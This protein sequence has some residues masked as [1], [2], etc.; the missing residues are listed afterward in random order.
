AVTSLDL[1]GAQLTVANGGI[2]VGS[3]HA[4]PLAISNGTMTTGGANDLIIHN[5]GTGG[6]TISVDIVGATQSV[7]YAGT[8]V[9]TLVGAKT[10]TGT[11]YL[12][13][14]TV[15]IAADTSLGNAANALYFNGGELQTTHTGTQTIARNIT[16]GGDAA[17]IETVGSTNVTTLSGTIA[18]EGNFIYTETNTSTGGVVNA[19]N[20]DSVGVGD[21]IKTGAGTLVISGGSNTNW[22]GLMDVREG[23]LKIDI[24]DVAS[25]TAFQRNMGTNESWLDATIVRNGATLNLN[26]VGTANIAAIGEWFR[27]EDNT[28]IAV[29]GGRFGTSGLME[30]QGAL[31][32]D[33]AGGAQFDQQGNGGYMFGNGNITKTGTGTWFLLGNNN[34]FTGSLTVLEGTLGARGQGQITGSDFNELITI[35][36]T[37]TNAEFRRL[38]SNEFVNNYLVENHNIRVTGTGTKTIGYGNGST[39]F[40]DDFIDFN[41]TITL[42]SAVVLSVNAPGGTR[43]QTGY[44]RFNGAFSSSGGVTTLVNS[45]SATFS[46]TGV[47]ELNADNTSWSGGI[48][49]GNTGNTTPFNIHILRLGNN[50]ALRSD[51]S[52]TLRHDATL[53]AGGRTV[54][55]G[56]L[57][58]SGN[59]GA[60]SNEIVENAAHADGTI[61]FTQTTDG[62][63]DALFRD[64]TPIGTIYEAD[65]NTTVGKL[66]L[67]KEGS[68]RA[69]LML[70]NLYTGSTTV[71]AGILQVGTGG[72]AATRA[73]GDTGTGATT[74]VL[75]VNSG[76]RVAGTGTVQGIASTTTHFVTGGGIISPGDVT[77][78]LSDPTGIG[79]LNVV[80]NLNVS[81]GVI[82]LQA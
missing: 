38:S 69:T 35:G 3:G 29:T 46:R 63:W 15:S 8:G 62:N 30:V 49:V 20:T 52:V 41:G 72:T 16:I 24:A 74:S 54:T 28:K 82:Q 17:Y 76:G 13:G 73:V 21:M 36:G 14:G 66:N 19:A 51:N 48:T 78:A 1:G 27:M 34:L 33:V 26:K 43:A 18:S 50:N 2:L 58:T 44:M 55:A 65:G 25:G 32:V 79:T 31:T 22:A 10:Y 40:G 61:A 12:V 23:T 4:G 45:G 42:D 59:V 7:T 57:T 37:G 5:Y 70:D 71:N 47:F 56:N 77:T 11:T 6:L 60:T 68:A 53:Q 81:T 9:T 75:T 39:P 80:G 64:G 67:V